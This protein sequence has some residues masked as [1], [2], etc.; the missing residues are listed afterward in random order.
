MMA[1]DHS[2]FLSPL[3][4]NKLL[5]LI[6]LNFFC[7][8]VLPLFKPAPLLALCDNGRTGP[9]IAHHYEFFSAIRTG[10]DAANPG[11]PGT[12]LPVTILLSADLG[13]SAE[14][15][16]SVIS[17]MS[18]QNLRPIIRITG[19]FTGDYWTKITN[20]QATHAANILT[21]AINLTGVT[22]VIVYFGNEPDLPYE[23]ANWP[24]ATMS[25]TS[26]TQRLEE[27]AGVFR[28]FALA[29]QGAPYDVYIP[30]LALYQSVDF[31]LEQSWL[32]NIILPEVQGLVDGA[33][34][35]LYNANYSAL[36]SDYANM[37]NFYNSRGISSIIVSEVGPRV[38]GELLQ[39]ACQIE[40]WKRIMSDAFSHGDSFLPG[41][42]VVNTSFFWDIDCDGHPDDTALVIIDQAGNTEIYY[43]F[44]GQLL[45]F[46]EYLEITG[47]GYL[48]TECCASSLA[49]RTLELPKNGT[50]TYGKAVFGRNVPC[51]PIISRQT[52]WTEDW[53]DREKVCTIDITSDIGFTCTSTSD[54]GA[55]Y[56]NPY[57]H[58]CNP[59]NMTNIPDDEYVSG[60]P[61]D[62]SPWR[63]FPGDSGRFFRNFNVPYT[64]DYD[65]FI[66]GQEN[67]NGSYRVNV[68]YDLERV[69]DITSYCNPAPEIEDIFN[70]FPV[71]SVEKNLLAQ[72]KFR[73]WWTG[74]SGGGQA[75]QIPF[76]G[77]S[78]TSS[79]NVTNNAARMSNFL[80]D[81]LRGTVFWDRTWVDYND[82]DD[83]RRILDEGGPLRKLYPRDI[84]MDDGYRAQFAACRL[85]KGQTYGG[86]PCDKL[87]ST[88][89]IHDYPVMW[90]VPA[91][92]E[93]EF[94]QLP[95]R[96]T[97]EATPLRISE[98]FC[99][100]PDWEDENI[101][102]QNDF[103][104][105]G[106]PRDLCAEGTG[107]TEWGLHESADLFGL[108]GPW[109]NYFPLTSKEDVP[110]FVDVSFEGVWLPEQFGL[111]PGLG[112]DHQP[113]IAEIYEAIEGYYYPI[114]GC[115]YDGTNVVCNENCNLE[116]AC[117][118]PENLSTCNYDLISCPLSD[119]FARYNGMYYVRLP[120]NTDANNVFGV[121]LPIYEF[122]FV[123]LVF[124]PHVVES[125]ELAEW[126][127]RPLLPQN[128]RNTSSGGF[129][130]LLLPSSEACNVNDIARGGV[131]DVV[132][133]DWQHSFDANPLEFERFLLMFNAPTAT[134]GIDST[135]WGC[136]TPNFWEFPPREESRE[137]KTGNITTKIPYLATL[138]QDT[139]GPA[140]VLTALMPSGFAEDVV[141]TISDVTAGKVNWWELPGY[142]PASYEY[143]NDLTKQERNPHWGYCENPPWSA[144]TCG[145]SVILPEGCGVVT[146]FCQDWDEDG[147]GDHLVGTLSC[148]GELIPNQVIKTCGGSCTNGA[149]L[150]DICECRNDNCYCGTGG[151]GCS[152]R[153]YN[154]YELLGPPFPNESL[155]LPCNCL[156]VY[157]FLGCDV[158]DPPCGPT[159]AD[160]E[161]LGEID[162]RGY[163]QVVNASEAR[164]Y[165]P[166][167]GTI[168]IFRRYLTA[169]VLPYEEAYFSLTSVS[170]PANLSTIY[171]TGTSL[172]YYI[173]FRSS[174]DQFRSDW[175]QVAQDYLQ[176]Q[177]WVPNG[178]QDGDY[179]T[180]IN[181]AQP[182]GWN[183]VFLVALWIEETG[184]SYFTNIG[185][186]NEHLGCA[187]S[188]PKSLEESLDCIQRNFSEYTNDMFEEFMCRYSEGFA[189][190]CPCNFVINPNFPAR[191]RYFY[192]MIA[193]S[194]V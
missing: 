161:W 8:T 53:Y 160:N 100:N 126:V 56:F 47:N 185:V 157:S 30:P 51:R 127:R 63:P 88:D 184:A 71:S 110:A 15:W 109:K 133:G 147:R 115:F 46:S 91:V 33:A 16:A 57:C 85:F 19:A 21:E 96:R 76:L 155:L 12:R 143:V 119:Q 97:T 13:A 150:P 29:S 81:F 106:I 177:G 41:A 136:Q 59:L 163:G 83:Y 58:E 48:L 118:D 27:F 134:T 168:D 113:S 117:T 112:L 72:G 1:K 65:E 80:A 77:N 78:F 159:V 40:E 98:F 104:N 105:W 6:F 4:K 137:S 121:P 25:N 87:I 140:G 42:S 116:T 190:C 34:L 54:S 89:P 69:G 172:G 82:E 125:R 135:S 141:E 146:Q 130:G 192:N 43:P 3:K 153:E 128:A 92:S 39:E 169:Q 129:G 102:T 191:I 84:L 181:F 111:P 120:E 138:A 166:Y 11:C 101:F 5:I 175:I 154:L 142:G 144:S 90:G 123:D 73:A 162:W 164:F 152:P 70:W 20:E 26:V 86:V 44:N 114:E 68:C 7:L 170:A 193:A 28:T 122:H 49:D 171:G 75:T 176:G 132:A 158:C 31:S 18:A 38:G 94:T 107:A 189:P 151:T 50:T 35:T 22:D 194:T 178:I 36:N 156:G 124:I 62:Y 55:S 45:T 148:N 66:A 60:Y 167:I 179:Q 108:G 188:V 67:N 174:G 95:D 2:I 99:G 182:N 149:G 24:D 37:R 173:N 74:K 139:I 64:Q 9:K 165:F 23:W 10:Y 61:F 131:G 145:S 186:S 103:Q 32:D 14:G 17:A 79:T 180:I 183:P 187:P 52:P 93:S